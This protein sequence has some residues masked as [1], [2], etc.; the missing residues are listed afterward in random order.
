MP[1]EQQP[2]LLTAGELRAGPHAHTRKG[3]HQPLPPA[4]PPQIDLMYTVLTKATGERCYYPNTRLLTLPLVNLSRTQ[5]KAEAVSLAVDTGRA[6]LAAR[7]ALS[8]RRRG[9]A[10]GGGGSA[11]RQGTMH[12]SG[13]A[14]HRLACEEL[15]QAARC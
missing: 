10:R 8:V 15:G 14:C 4:P 11:A 5:H 6:G 9:G 12:G 3:F 7:K 13:R 1:G 2:T